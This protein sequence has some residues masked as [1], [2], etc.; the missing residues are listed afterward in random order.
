[1]GRTD[2][3][4]ETPMLWPP[5]G[6]NQLI[7]KDP[8]AGKDS[9]QVEKGQQRMRLLGQGDLACCGPWVAKS[10]TQLSN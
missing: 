1:M 6:K 7:V 4:A 8:D 9:R 2:A 3:E 10:R 5:D